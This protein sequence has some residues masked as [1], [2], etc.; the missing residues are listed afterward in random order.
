LILFTRHS[1]ERMKQR[2]ISRDTV[3]R[4][5]DSPNSVVPDNYGNRVAQVMEG[6]T[7][8]RVVFRE[9]GRD[10]LVITVYRTTRLQKYPKGL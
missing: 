1:L 10:L 4:A 3:I 9:E 6:D 5:I 8:L 7:M 2:G